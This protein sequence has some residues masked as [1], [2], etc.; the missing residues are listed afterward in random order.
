[1][2]NLI[3]N[4]KTLPGIGGKTAERLAFSMLGFDKNQLTN[5]SSA[6][7]DIRDRIKNCRLC[8]NIAEEDLCSICSNKLV[9]S[10][11]KSKCICVSSKNILKQSLYILFQLTYSSLI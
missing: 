11:Y 5:F 4:L 1:M 8:G 3:D 6:I 2:K 10:L 9:L 7:I